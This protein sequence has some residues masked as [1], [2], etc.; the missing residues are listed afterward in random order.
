MNKSQ[1]KAKKKSNYDDDESYSIEDDDY[2]I[3]EDSESGFDG[4]ELEIDEISIKGKN[5]KKTI[6][7]KNYII[8][9][10]N[11]EDSEK[12][13]DVVNKEITKKKL[14]KKREREKEKKNPKPK[15]L[16]YE[17][18]SNGAEI[19][20]QKPKIILTNNNNN[21]ITNTNNNN[22]I[23]NNIPY[24]YKKNYFYQN[25]TPTEWNQISSFIESSL[26]QPNIDNN[27]L[28]NFFLHYPNMYKGE[29][30]LKK[31]FQIL[32][33]KSQNNTSLQ[34]YKTISNYLISN[35]YMPKPSIF[36]VY[37]FPNPDNE[38]YVINMLQTCK[39]SIDIAIF[40]MTNIK[41]ANIISSLFNRGI[42]IRII[43]DGEC[44]KM[45][46]SN[47]YSLAALGIDIKTD[48]SI[49]Y[50]MH[51][52]FAVIDNSVVITGS[53][54][55]TTQAVN[56]NQENILF[57]ENKNL[58][59]KYSIEFQRLWDDFEVVISKESAIRILKDEE[60]KKKAIES[61]KRK[62]KERKL[63]LKESMKKNKNNEN[64]DNKVNISIKKN[65]S[66]M[67]KSNA[68]KVFKRKNNDDCV[69]K[70]DFGEKENLI[71]NQNINNINNVELRE[72]TNIENN[73]NNN[74]EKDKKC[75]IF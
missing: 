61:R 22:N 27:T 39:N 58:A 14:G 53:F 17:N 9:E 15:K 55:W 28:Q 47:I 44:C 62:E 7:K 75:T 54:N 74:K 37:F 69:K 29:H 32:N 5:K 25:I 42:K 16:K 19:I 13:N 34:S 3:D 12:L 8:E 60:E 51:H 68:K 57:L 31:L 33:D 50:Y 52:K 70:I 56:H 43:A 65:N 2:N 49:R 21:N 6:R 36:E 40:T 73:D 4:D 20:N 23:I 67:K 1:R 48:D 35:Y 41:I 18:I 24:D 71:N 45:Q 10:E 64:N 63:A 59:K 46:S 11:K 66:C 26:K 38:I 30:N 72:I